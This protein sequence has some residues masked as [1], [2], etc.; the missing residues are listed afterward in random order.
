MPD[1]L[2]SNISLAV[3]DVPLPVVAG[4]RFSIKA[5]AKAHTGSPLAGR[6]IEVCDATGAVVASGRLGAAPL[7]DTGALYWTTLDIPAP[8]AEGLAEFTVRCVA[9]QAEPDTATWRFSIAMVSK[10]EHRL[11]IR[12]FDKDSAAALDEVEIRLGAFHARTDASGRAEMQVSA[13]DYQVLAWKAAYGAEPTPLAV[14]GDTSIE[15]AM[16]HIPE[17]HPDA[18]WVM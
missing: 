15:I 17:E 12:V 5:G 13:G 11:N 1:D 4:K 18:R 7:P 2:A 6:V 9:D 14:N 16:V 10:P 3:W 8:A